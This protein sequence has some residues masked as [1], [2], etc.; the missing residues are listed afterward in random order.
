MKQSLPVH[1][2][3]WFLVPVSLGN[4]LTPGVKHSLHGPV[5]LH[6][7]LKRMGILYKVG[8][9]ACWCNVYQEWHVC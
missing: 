9:K 4:E 5:F 6:H 7:D 8:V 1:F 2:K 3:V